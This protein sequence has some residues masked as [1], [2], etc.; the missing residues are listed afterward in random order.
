MPGRSS[1]SCSAAPGGELGDLAGH[2][3]TGRAA[4][5]DDEGEPCLSSNFVRLG[6]GDLEGAEDAAR[7]SS[8]SS[9]DF[10]PGAHWVNSS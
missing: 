8:A 6:L 4:T 5:D 1:G 10:M 2:L 3:H 7:S 9:I